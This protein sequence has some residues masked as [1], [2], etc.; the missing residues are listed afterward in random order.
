M[1][2]TALRNQQAMA[3][4]HVQQAQ[5]AARSAQQDTQFAADNHD[6][7]LASAQIHLQQLQASYDSM[8]K[9]FQD[10]LLQEGAEAGQ[11]LIQN[12]I[13]PVFSGDE[14]DA[15]AHLQARMSVNADA[16]LNVTMLP[17]GNGGFNVFELPNADKTFNHSVDLT[18]GHDPNG[19]PIKK[20]YAAG[21]ISIARALNLE[22]AAMVDYSKVAGK[23]QTANATNVSAKNAAAANKSNAAAASGGATSPTTDSLGV[24]ITPPA[25]GAKAQT[26]IQ[27][28]F[29]KD[30]DDLSKTESTYDAF[31]DALNDINSGKDITGAKSV[32]TLFNAIGLSATPLKGM[33]MRI[34]Q[35]TVAEHIDARGVGQ[36]LYGKLLK[37]QDGDVITPQQI[38]DYASIASQARESAYVNKINEARSYG[39]DPSFL[40]PS[41][42]GRHVDPNTAKIFV[43]A[44]NGNKD[45]AR[46]AA[47][48]KGWRF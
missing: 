36:S 43:A 3:T 46:K 40:L 7:Q 4:A 31:Q 18:I 35:N 42:N 29:K 27:G 9:D 30:A 37:V 1:A 25:G 38:K 10:H 16:P 47:Q 41:G 2:D 11:H 8:P 34:N 44:A 12:G 22:T 39:L 15:Q 45:A 23:I 48:A 24:A 13:Q 5:A 14:A 19:E 6:V 33:G 28:Q 26:K 20:T 21:T 32:V 17:D